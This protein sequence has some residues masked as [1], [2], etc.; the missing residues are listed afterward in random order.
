MLLKLAAGLPSRSGTTFI[1]PV[2]LP[3][4]SLGPQTHTFLCLELSCSE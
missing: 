1:L 3:Q 2:T 4:P